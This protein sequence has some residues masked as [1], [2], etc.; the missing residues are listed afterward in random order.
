MHL[1]I[2]QLYLSPGSVYY[3]T[4][5]GS[6]WSRQSKIL[7]TD[8][9]ASDQFGYSVSIYNNAAFIGAF[10]DDDKALDAGV[11]LYMHM[12]VFQFCA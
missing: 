12:N 8:G 5:I 2:T 6:Y 9:A 10:K 4:L 11:F 7:A 3:Y 1:S